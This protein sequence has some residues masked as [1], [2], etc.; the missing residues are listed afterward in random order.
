MIYSLIGAFLAY[1]LVFA[2][3]YHIGRTTGYRRG[4][5]YAADV[6]T[7]RF[8]KQSQL[9]EN[10][11]STKGTRRTYDPSRSCKLDNNER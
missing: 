6:V 1:A 5:D 4:L 3:G 10:G 7:R 11:S 2:V 8:I 9:N